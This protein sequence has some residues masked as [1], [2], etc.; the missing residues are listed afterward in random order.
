VQFANALAVGP[1]LG[2]GTKGLFVMR[3]ASHARE[4]AAKR[5]KGSATLRAPPAEKAIFNF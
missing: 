1:D 5:V 4:S 3:D 2:P